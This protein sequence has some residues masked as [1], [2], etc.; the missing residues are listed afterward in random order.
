MRDR[1]EGTFM[2]DK[3]LTDTVVKEVGVTS[4]MRMEK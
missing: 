1:E 3:S 2:E 4:K